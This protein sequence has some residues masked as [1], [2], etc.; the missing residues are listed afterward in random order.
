MANEVKNDT[1]Q[2]VVVIYSKGEKI[3]SR[4]FKE[5]SEEEVRA[6]ATEWVHRWG[7]KVDWSL[8]HVV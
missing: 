4:V 8:H 5:S 6:K 3:T 1:G 2:W 7:E